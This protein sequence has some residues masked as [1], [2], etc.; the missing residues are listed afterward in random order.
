M[1]ASQWYRARAGRGGRGRGSDWDIAEDVEAFGPGKGAPDAGF[2]NPLPVIESRSM[3]PRSETTEVRADDSRIAGPLAHSLQ[4]GRG[5]PADPE[6]GRGS[7]N[8]H[9]RRAPAATALEEPEGALPSPCN[10][11][12][13][14][15][16]HL[17]P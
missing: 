13:L 2:S 6:Y 9:G 11:N 17:A 1:S 15:P 7:A 16:R 8:G 12:S 5:M 3:A 4:A 10:L 14:R